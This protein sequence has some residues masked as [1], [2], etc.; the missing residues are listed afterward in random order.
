MKKRVFRKRYEDAIEALKAFEK[1]EKVE[2]KELTVEKT[3]IEE[4]PLKPRKER[5]WKQ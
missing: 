1:L 3:N 2:N 4:K 5:I